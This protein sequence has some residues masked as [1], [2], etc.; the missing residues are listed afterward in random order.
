MFVLLLQLLKR[1]YVLGVS[2]IQDDVA[3]E[4]WAVLAPTQPA[5]PLDKRLYLLNT[6][7]EIMKTFTR[8]VDL[9]VHMHK[10]L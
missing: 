8:G 2:Y 7:H 6:I 4:G 9:M 3:G 10:Y 5:K 1:T